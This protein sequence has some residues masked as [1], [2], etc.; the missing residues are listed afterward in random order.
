[1]QDI[2]RHLLGLTRGHKMA[3][4]LIMDCAA[5]VAAFAAA[6]WLR[7][8]SLMFL[9]NPQVWLALLP[10]IPVALIVLHSLGF[11]RGLKLRILRR[12]K[13]DKSISGASTAS[14]Y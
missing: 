9:T 7:L 2:Y 1:M 8:D 13:R 6:M 3:I 11:Y 14:Y 4:Q 5:M 10:A 12:H